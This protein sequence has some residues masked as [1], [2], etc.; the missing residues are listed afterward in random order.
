MLP[1]SEPSPRRSISASTVWPSSTTATRS[2][3][4]STEI[5]IVLDTFDVSVKCVLLPAG[6][7]GMIRVRTSRL[8]FGG[9][10]RLRP[11]TACAI[12]SGR[13]VPVVGQPKLASAAGPARARCSSSTAADVDRA[14]RPCR[15]RFA[16][17]RSSSAAANARSARGPVDVVLDLHVVLGRI[18]ARGGRAGPRRARRRPRRMPCGSCAS[19]R[20]ATLGR[21]VVAVQAA[22]SAR[23]ACRLARPPPAAARARSRA[24]LHALATG[25][26]RSRRAAAR[27]S[28]VS[29]V[30]R[31][32]RKRARPPTAKVI[33]YVKDRSQL[34]A[35]RTGSTPV[36]VSSPICCG[37][38]RSRRRNRCSRPSGSR[39][40]PPRRGSATTRPAGTPWRRPSCT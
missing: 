5:R 14:D 23:S 29:T 6:R 21:V 9:R 20:S 8:M 32:D 28:S 39:R 1:A 34:S 40:S 4:R 37:R 7:A 16:P 11:A 12:S 27:P 35:G 22:T 36:P 30:S 18:D 31:C 38:G 33:R 2:S 3:D 17:P 24:W 13:A 19:S 10:G 25:R 15:G 26:S